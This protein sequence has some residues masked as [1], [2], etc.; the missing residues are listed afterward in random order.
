MLIGID[1]SRANSVHRTGTEWYSFF[2][3]KH[4]ARVIG[5]EH[6]VFL[7]TREPMREDLAKDLPKY[8]FPRYL[9]WPPKFLWTQL[10][11]SLEMLFQKPQVLFVP[12][13]T[14]PLIHPRH[15]VVTLHDIGFERMEQLYDFH[16]IA[17]EKVLS[18]ILLKWLVKIFTFGRFSNNELDYHKWA[19]R[20]ALKRAEHI[21]TVSD[22]S[23][24]EI[25]DC[26][27][28]PPEKITRIYNSFDQSLFQPIR[29]QNLIK[30]VL[31]QYHLQ[32]PYVLFVGRLEQKKNLPKLIE[33]WAIFKQRSGLPHKLVLAG[34]PGFQYE[35]IQAKIQSLRVQNSVQETGYVAQEDLPVI[36]SAADAYVFPSLYEGFGI[37]ALEAFACGTPLLASRIASLPEIAGKGAYYFNPLDAGDMARALEKVLCSK[38]LQAQLR[39]AGKA[40]LARFSWKETARQTWDVLMKYGTISS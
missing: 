2:L 24:R 4:L 12:A 28:F 6:K 26:Y 17:N 18:K 7:Y 40:E 32:Q 33:A 31:D 25:I 30:R 20:F 21:L 37:P 16:P 22:F 35:L 19:T 5:P 9:A 13:H 10:R 36:L 15:T 38:E 14:M 29:D 8:F 27:H 1:A 11:L 39:E 3:I 34:M 23:R